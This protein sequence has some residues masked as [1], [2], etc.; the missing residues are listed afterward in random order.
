MGRESFP[1]PNAS[2]IIGPSSFIGNA[3]AVRLLGN[4]FR[5]DH[6]FYPWLS[7]ATAPQ[8]R[9]E[10]DFPFLALLPSPLLG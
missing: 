1:H 5:A 3:V 8:L 9:L 10:R 2:L 6:G 7:N 4:P